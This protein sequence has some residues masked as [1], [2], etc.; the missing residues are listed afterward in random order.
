MNARQR[1]KD[2]RGLSRFVTMSRKA[3]GLMEKNLES[4]LT[5]YLSMLAMSHTGMAE[6][7]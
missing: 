5:L 6:R 2:R 4:D 7:K 3:L 1:R